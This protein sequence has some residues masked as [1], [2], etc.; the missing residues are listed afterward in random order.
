MNETP[1]TPAAMW[2][3]LHEWFG[4]GTYD[5][6]LSARPWHRERMV[7][8]SKLKALLKSRR[9]S[10]AEVNIAAEYAR[11]HHQPIQHTWQVFAL[12]PEAMRERFRHATQARREAAGDELG[13]A[14]TEALEAGEYEW[15]ERLMRAQDPD[16]VV[17]A[18]RT[19]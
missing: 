7:E 8:I 2:D 14:I 18:W 3:R 12:I 19:R 17:A 16:A 1:K 10:L 13:A 9:A 6:A 5:E 4:I 11:R 15:A